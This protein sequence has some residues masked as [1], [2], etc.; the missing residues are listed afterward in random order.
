MLF[1]GGNTSIYI[2]DMDRSIRFYVESLGLRLLTRIDNEWAEL[3]AG[4]G[5]IIGLHPA[6]PPTTPKPGALGAFNIE[7]RV[8]GSLDAAVEA[9]KSRGVRFTKPILN[10]EHVRLASFTDPDKN[11]LLLA[12]TIPASKPS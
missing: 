2:S 3:D 4:G 9:L 1:S 11:V 12:Q 10:Y 8:I 7:F 6:N 5:M